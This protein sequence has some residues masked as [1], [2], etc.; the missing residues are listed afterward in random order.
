MGNAFSD[1]SGSSPAHALTNAQNSRPCES[2]GYFSEIESTHIR[3]VQQEAKEVAMASVNDAVH[4]ILAIWRH[5]HHLGMNN[6]EIDSL[7]NIYMQRYK[8]IETFCP[9]LNSMKS[10]TCALRQKILHGIDF[11][12]FV[13][14]ICSGAYGNR[15]TLDFVWDICCCDGEEIHL[16]QTTPA[17]TIVGICVEIAELAHHMTLDQELE[18]SRNIKRVEAVMESFTNSL[19]E[20][21]NS[22]NQ[23]PSFDLGGSIAA[24]VP[25]T[26]KKESISKRTFME[27]HRKV[28]PDLLHN[29]V[30]KF[31]LMLFFPPRH[32]LIK[33]SETLFRKY[34]RIVLHSSKELI[35]R[36]AAKLKEGEVVPMKSAVFGQNYAYTMSPTTNSLTECAATATF[37]PEVFALTTMSASKFGNEV[38]LCCV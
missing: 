5:A 21:A 31:F 34:N 15:T 1:C 12:E 19:L 13:S 4:L 35:P 32:Y 6:S 24:N 10:L 27:W 17:K 22:S 7:A 11:V 18:E 8:T 9:C 36:T 30:G 23:D 29:S 25:S 14:E 26:E 38:C 37:P 28:T 2:N 33:Q 16:E 3:Q 20:Y